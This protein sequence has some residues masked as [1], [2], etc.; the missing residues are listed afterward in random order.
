[1]YCQSPP[2]TEYA[3]A[4]EPGRGRASQGRPGATLREA[5]SLD[6]PALAFA[7]RQVDP[8]TRGKLRARGGPLGDDPALLGLSRRHLGDS[9]EL[10]AGV[11]QCEHRLHE[12]L[13]ADAGDYTTGLGGPES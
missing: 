7:D 13:A 5:E 4:E 6:G 12:R 3:K 1:M 11:A 9:S 8:R 10:A 2:L